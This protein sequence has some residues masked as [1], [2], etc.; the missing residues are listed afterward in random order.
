M[1]SFNGINL[2]LTN[3]PLNVPNPK[4]RQSIAFPGLNGRLTRDLGTDGGQIIVEGLISGTSLSDLTNQEQIWYTYQSNGGFYP[5]VD[6]QSRTK[7]CYLDMYEPLEG[8]RQG[9]DGSG[10]SWYRKARWTFVYNS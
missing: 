5:F 7:S 8:M 9:S 1:A 3:E 2:S 4:R 10:G 6:N